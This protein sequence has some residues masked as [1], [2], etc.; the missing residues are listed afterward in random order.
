MTGAAP[1]ASETSCRNRSSSGRPGACEPFSVTDC[2][3]SEWRAVSEP[4]SETKA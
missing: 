2:E 4:M 3:P 1:E